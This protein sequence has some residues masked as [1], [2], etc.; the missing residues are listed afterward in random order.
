MND[1]DI[2]ESSAQIMKD[3]I[4]KEQL[5]VL[6]HKIL[7]LDKEV[8]TP[9]LSIFNDTLCIYCQGGDKPEERNIF[10]NDIYPELGDTEH[11]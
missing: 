6:V 2:F 5:R 4:A 11:E 3:N 9:C 8:Y 1:S 7:Y 10:S